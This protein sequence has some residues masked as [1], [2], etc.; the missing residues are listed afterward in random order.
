MNT[1]FTFPRPQAAVARQQA[2]RAAGSSQPNARESN[3]LRASVLDA[4]LELGIGSNPLVA[5]WMFNNA[6][7]EED[8]EEPAFALAFEVYKISTWLS[9]IGDF[10]ASLPWE[11][12]CLAV[13]RYIHN[14]ISS[15]NGIRAKTIGLPMLRSDQVSSP[16]LTYGSSATSEESSFSVLTSSSSISSSKFSGAGAPFAP[17]AKSAPGMLRISESEADTA[18][19]DSSLATNNAVTFPDVPTPPRPV[20]P[21]S[22]KLKKKQRGD[23][24]E[25][26]GGYISE[27]A[28]KKKDKKKADSKDSKDAVVFPSMETPKE[29]KKRAKEKKE[30]ADGERKRKKS[31]MSAVKA[32]KKSEAKEG[33]KGYDTDGGGILSSGKKVKPKKSKSKLPSE[34]M[35]A[36]YETDGAVKKSKTRFFKLSSKASR[37]DLRAEAVPAMPMP[38]P[39]EVIPLPIAERFATTLS[40]TPFSPTSPT[41]N[42]ATTPPVVSLPPGRVEGSS[43]PLPPLAFQPFA[44]PTPTSSEVAPPVSR[45]IPPSPIL[46]AADRTSHSSSESSSSAGLNPRRQ[47]GQFSP[48]NSSGHGQGSGSY[49]T[50]TSNHTSEA[51]HFP[52]NGSTPSPP[53]SA[54]VSVGPAHLKPPSISYP[55]TRS[56]SPV[57]SGISPMGTPLVTPLQISKGGLRVRPSLENMGYLS[58]ENSPSPMP[59]S[60]ISPFMSTPLRSAVSSPTLGVPAQ[61]YS[62][63]P[64][65][66]S[67]RLR[68]R[69]PAGPPSTSQNA[70]LSPLYS[71]NEQ[72]QLTVNTSD[73]VVPSPRNS[74]LPSPNVLA[75][76]DIPPPSPPPMG[77]L[78]TVPPHA[79]SASASSATVATSP[80]SASM[81]PVQ[82]PSA[83]VLRQRVIDRTPR[84]LP[85]NIQRGKESPFPSRPAPP[86]ASMPVTGTRRY[87]DLYPQGTLNSEPSV[88]DRSYDDVD[89]PRERHARFRDELSWIN[90]DT[91]TR[92]SSQWHEDEGDVDEGEYSDGDGD[93][94]DDLNGSAEDLQRVLDRFEDRSSESGEHIQPERALERSHSPQMLKE[95][96]NPNPNHDDRD[97][98]S[99][100]GYYGSQSRLQSKAQSRLTTSTTTELM[101]N[102]ES[103]YTFE[104]GRTVGDR[105]SRWSGSIYSRAS[106]LDAGA[107]GETRERLVKQVEEMLAKEARSG[108][109]SSS[110]RSA[111]VGLDYIPPVPRLPDAYANANANLGRHAVD[112]GVI[113][114]ATPARSWNRF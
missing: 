94:D 61:P 26:D 37:P 4:A 48:P 32:S 79:A 82:F 66:P 25:S 39:K 27:V 104:D 13:C 28:G 33:D 43:T 56:V 5:D 110:S 73:Y 90:T 98:L 111:G 93:V 103:Q 74:G 14:A 86:S 40:P 11:R 87:R 91:G 22:R 20:T 1:T 113:P 52:A 76:Y 30:M 99:A 2:P 15:L 16:S 7:A 65:S 70:F 114:E 102:R 17:N 23:G 85:A 47:A 105:T 8:E 77:P 75:Y 18:A 34:D 10:L 54:G 100:S 29:A 49:S 9:Y 36:G 95:R 89:G 84:Q 80:N 45:V 3:A 88:Q 57:P 46:P 112:A 58:R 44:P 69:S 63:M 35:A 67:G 71:A 12:V 53:N 38:M 96:S 21:A 64:G 55:N 72:S 109:A 6:L 92:A 101:Y 108:G 106:I 42:S 31:L 97:P 60:P 24:Y 83:A 19:F 62:G 68:S 59:I 51:S 78:P 50:L 107:S 81:N 41:Q